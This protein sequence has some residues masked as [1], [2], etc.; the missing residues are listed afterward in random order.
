M[1]KSKADLMKKKTLPRV[2]KTICLHECS[3]L[4][5]LH[6]KNIIVTESM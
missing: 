3:R 1:E 6:S 2:A 4:K 5:V